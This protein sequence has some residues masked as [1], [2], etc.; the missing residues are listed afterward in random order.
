MIFLINPRGDPFS[1]VTCID[2]HAMALQGQAGAALAIAALG[3]FFAGTVCT[4]I[5]ALIGPVLADVALRFGA[6][7][8]FSLMLMGLVCA[9]VLGKGSLLKSLAMVIVGLLLGIIGTDVNSGIPRFTFDLIGLSD[10]IGFV[11]VAMGVFG[12]AEI[13]SNLGHMQIER[14]V[15][16]GKVTRLWPSWPDFRCSVGPVLRGTAIGAFFGPLPGTGSTIASFAS[17]ALEKKLSKT[18]SRFGRGAIEG[19]AGPEAA[20]NASTQTT[21]IPMLTLG[22]PSSASMALMLGAMMIYGIAPGPQVMTSRPD[23]FWGLIASMWIGNAMLLC[24]N[25]PL[26]RIWVRLLQV[27]YRILFHIIVVLMA[28]GVYSL[29]SAAFDVY[30]MALF[31]L[32]G[33]VWMKLKCDMA[34]FLLAFLLGPLMEE[35]LRRALLISRGDLSVFFTRPISAAFMIT[36]ALLLLAFAIPMFRKKRDEVAENEKQV[37]E[38]AENEKPVKITPDPRLWQRP[39]SGEWNADEKERDKR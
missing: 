16:V 13:I 18:P 35:H 23:L 2:G 37:N 19:V 14:S 7:E 32:L 1:V 28:I 12:L 25:L 29:S 10:G 27:P 17:Y 6:P 36:T 26:I 4:L 30:M 20:N 24:L 9:A 33:Y 5:I 3:S 38:V 39:I 8:Y 15:V 22:I 34:P 31:G 21:F 11:V